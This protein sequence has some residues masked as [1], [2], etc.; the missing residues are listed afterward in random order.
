M[1]RTRL[2]APV[3]GFGA[4][5]L[6]VVALSEL[7][8]AFTD[9]CQTLAD[10]R[11]EASELL[12]QAERLMTQSYDELLRKMRLMG[13]TLYEEALDAEVSLWAESDAEWGRGPGY[14][15]RVSGRRLEW[16]TDTERAALENQLR[17]A[18]A[19][20]WDGLLA[21]IRMIFD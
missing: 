13:S 20:E 4:R 19:R 17:D 3:A 7:V 11:P 18:L 2:C 1:V 15:D 6:A 10:S 5:R 14:R 8:D 12:A 9:T 21:R 16:F